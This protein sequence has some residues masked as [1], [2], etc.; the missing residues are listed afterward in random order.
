M[1]PSLGR[2]LAIDHV[3]LTTDDV[4]ATVRDL[5][6]RAGLA[7]IEGGRH[8]GHGTGNWL[9]PL[10]DSYLEL[11]TVHDEEEARQSP[12]GSWVLDRPAHGLSLVCLRTDDADAIAARTGHDP[13]PM[14]RRTP[15]GAE[16]R[17]RL[18][19][20]EAALSQA[21]LPFFIEWDLGDTPHPGRSPAP[22][23]STP[24][25]ITALTWGGDERDFTDWVGEHDLPI[26]HEPGPPGPRS[27][28]IAT[29]DG[30]VVLHAPN[31]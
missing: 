27:V 9:V 11:L 22:H 30:P 18:V 26:H 15:D 16:L 8:E 6:E 5:R 10:G 31:A 17:W 13:S 23:E 29:D 3:I 25:G 7:A 1:P 24:H 2:M 20:L 14:S 19:G 12:F 4:R 21:A 28:T